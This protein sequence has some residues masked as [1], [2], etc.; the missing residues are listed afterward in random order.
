MLPPFQVSPLETPI[1]SLFPFPGLPFGNPYPIPLPPTSMRV[2]P[3]PP[4]NSC[5]SAL[6]FHYKGALNTLWAKGLSSH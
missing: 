1:P 4:T 6:V 2:L 3:H 5:L